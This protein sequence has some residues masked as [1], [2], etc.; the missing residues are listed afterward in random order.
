MLTHAYA[1]GLIDGEG[2]LQIVR[3]T[4]GLAYG[5][6]M[7]MGM[8]KALPLLQSL[9]AV[10]GGTVRPHRAKTDRWA[11]AMCW[12]V[13]GVE[14]AEMLRHVGPFLR[15]K[16]E[17]AGHCL[18][19]EELRLS[20]PT[21]GAKGMRRLWT[22]DAS[23]KAG[24]LAE[25]VSRLN[26]KGPAEPP[27]PPEWFARHVEG[28]W[29]RPQGSLFGSQGWEP[30]SQTWPR[31]GSMRSGAC[32]RR[33]MLAPRSS[34]I[35]STYWPSPMT[36]NGGRT[37]SEEDVLA[38]GA[39]AR[40]KRQVGLESVARMWPTPCAQEDQKSPEAHIAMK[41]RMVGGPRST[42]TSLTVAAK[43]WPTATAGDASATCAAGYSTESGRHSGT[44][45][46][47]AIRL[48]ATPTAS[49]NSNRT[50][51][52]APTHGNG[53]GLVLAGRA[54]DWAS[55]LPDLTTS[56][57]GPKSSPSTRRLNPRFVAWLMGLPVGWTDTTTPLART[58]F[59]RWATESS[60]WLELLLCAYSPVGRASTCEAT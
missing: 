26:Q 16:A 6:R 50:T 1:A 7:D 17:Q 39:T 41:A 19:L 3:A 38:K 8:T 40:G 33:P 5:I 51:R 9:R 25:A 56:E 35:G 4:K 23:K 60:R 31:W 36:P 20:L 30:F 22:E 13:N 11:A 44:T 21:P 45:L 52:R 28:Q 48:W 24:R 12:T 42:V 53:H 49:D 58:S 43:L 10:Y 47:D 57:P 54:A 2:C 27:L 59:E 18:A 29:V 32:S 34:G 46:T 55:S 14:C 37:M 15:L